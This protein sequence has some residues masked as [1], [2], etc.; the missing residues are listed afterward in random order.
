MLFFLSIAQKRGFVVDTYVDEA[1]GTMGK[2]AEGKTAVTRVVLRPAATYVGERVPD[3][4]SL[5]RMHHRAHEL[6]FVANSVTSDI[7][8]DVIS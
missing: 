3:R 6:C 8:T 4:D 7:V 5:E 1:V 2:T